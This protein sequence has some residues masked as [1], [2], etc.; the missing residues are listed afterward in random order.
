MSTIPAYF[1]ANVDDHQYIEAIGESVNAMISGLESDQG[2]VTRSLETLKSS[3]QRHFITEENIMSDLS[4]G[5]LLEHSHSHILIVGEVGDCLRSI[6]G[7]DYQQSINIWPRVK[8]M[9]R[10]HVQRFDQD[11]VRHLEQAAKQ[12]G[13]TVASSPPLAALI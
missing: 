5:G 1:A 3:L 4:Y 13:L 12:P 2:Q 9:L 10:Y 6:A 11:L 7:G 8:A